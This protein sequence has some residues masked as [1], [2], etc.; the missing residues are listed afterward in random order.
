MHE[1]LHDL[2]AVNRAIISSLDYD[3]VLR[4]IVEKTAAFTHADVCVL[5]LTGSDDVARIVASYG[6]DEQRAQDFA[7]CFDERLGESLRPLLGFRERDVFVAAPVMMRHR[8]SGALVVFR[9]GPQPTGA[10][11]AMLVKALADQ[12]AIALEHASRF[13][14][15]RELSEHKSRLLEAIE[16]NTTTY[17]AYLDCKLSFLELNAAYCSAIGKS[18]VEVVG[19]SYAEVHPGAATTRALLERT[20]VSGA[21]AELQE[22]PL[23]IQR[24]GQATET[25]YWDWSARAVIGDFGRVNGVVVSAVDVTQK[26]LTRNELELANERKDEFLAMLAHELRNPLAA[27][28]TAVEV[29]RLCG[30]ADSR[31]TSSIDA[32]TRQVSHMKRLLDDLLDVSRITNGRIELRRSTVELGEVVAQAVQLSTPLV[33]R[34][35]QELTIELAPEPLF[36]DG[37]ADRLVQVLSNL[38]T[39]A[40][41]YTDV[42]GRIRLRVQPF[43]QEIRISVSDNGSGISP[44]ALPHIFDLFVQADRA[45]DRT[46]GGLG[47]G[48]TIVRRLVRMHGGRIE[49]RSE[50]R[51]RGSEFVIWLPASERPQPHGS[52]DSPPNASASQGLQVLLAE[53]NPDVAEMLS[54]MLEIEGHRVTVV[55]D[56]V[57][58]VEAALRDRPDVVLLDIG[59]PRLS[60]YEVARRLRT[61]M[62][63]RAPTLVA[64]TGYGREEDR[65]RAEAAGI[66]HHLVKPV[67][68]EQLRVILGRR[69]AA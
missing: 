31:A 19:R 12:A 6:I 51:G 67:E 55:G 7:A 65:A 3:E 41:K 42:G 11:E 2:I 8:V 49:A 63:E 47:I 34:R 30:S 27:I 35:G 39:N 26:V 32:A 28:S 46:D 52:G 44:E 64:L 45:I 61:S 9:R 69:R 58:A 18:A 20:C 50:G 10:D 21:A 62:G 14:E 57:A 43:A 38:L 56:G 54:A 16:S 13:R 29:L 53:D 15:V 59:L 33:R 4:L 48:L 24:E 23:T 22:T 68:L 25:V 1:R 17:L 66:D 36:V 60:G 40:A 5:L 37:D